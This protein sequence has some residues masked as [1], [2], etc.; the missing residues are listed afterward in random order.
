MAKNYRAE[1]TGVF[2]DPVDGNPT[3]VMEEAAYAACGLNYRY[4]T[5]KVTKD[6]FDDAMKAIHAFHMKGMN[7][8]MP[9]KINVIPY[10]DEL[11]EAARIIGA[12]NTIVVRDGKLFGE[13]TDGK[14][15]V[16]ALKNNDVSLNGKKIVILGAGGA[17]KAIAVECA[18][19]GAA[20]VTILNRTAARAEE[21]AEVLKSHTKAEASGM[22]LEPGQKIPADTDIL[23]NATCIGLHPDSDQKPDIDYDTIR[24]TMVVS[25]VVFNPVDTLFLQEAAKRGAK[26]VNGL[27]ML[28]CQGAL[29]FELW[30]G[31]KAPLEVMEETL[32]K[33]F[34][35]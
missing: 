9:H 25:D 29:N 21:L 4:L 22:A 23:I 8:T 27:G 30:T 33:E 28:A 18:L 3:G 7:L 17:A 32:R 16:Q 6:D 26:T 15:F 35:E 19:A 24:D 2:G 12:V 5:L 14:G 34:E 20:S 13:N 11:S 10:L 1:I 31:V